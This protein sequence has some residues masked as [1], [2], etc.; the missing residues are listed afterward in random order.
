MILGDV[1]ALG[2][3]TPST[4]T[5]ISKEKWTRWTMPPEDFEQMLNRDPPPANITNRDAGCEPHWIEGHARPLI[6]RS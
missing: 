5:L 2:A 6:K 1:T 4:R 3:D